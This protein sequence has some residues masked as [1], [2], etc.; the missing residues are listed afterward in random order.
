MVLAFAGHVQIVPVEGRGLVAIGESEYE[1]FGGSRFAQLAELIDGRREEQEILAAGDREALAGAIAELRRAGLLIDVPLPAGISG[2]TWWT[3]QGINPAVAEAR[4]RQTEVGVRAMPGVDRERT[5]G[6]MRDAGLR[7]ARAGDLGVVLVSDYLQDGLAEINAAALDDGRAW[8]LARPSGAQIFAGPVF[9]PHRGPCWECLAQRLREHRSLVRRMLV[10]AHAAD[11][12]GV[13]PIAPLETVGPSLIATE[14]VRWLAGAGPGLDSH[15]LSFDPRRW[16]G[17]RHRVV[18]RPQCPA[19]GERDA[20]LQRGAAPIRLRRRSGP[21]HSPEPLR[22]VA[23]EVMLE[24]FGHHISEVTGAVPGL[25]RHPGP[26][27]MHVY[28]TRAPAVRMHGDPDGWEHLLGAQ[29]SGKGTTDA[30]ARASALCEALERYSGQFAGDEPR[31]GGTFEELRSDAI[32]P[33]ACMGFSSA[34][35]AERTRSNREARS[36]RTYVP[37]PFDPTAPIDWTPAWSL[38]G[39][40]ERLLPT[41]LCYY[42][43]DVP[44]QDA[45]LADSNGNAAGNT[46]EEAVLHGLLELIERDHVALWWYNALAAPRV[47]LDS[48]DDTW[49][50]QVCRH[51]HEQGRDLWALDLTA[52]LG[53]PVSAALATSPDGTRVAMGYGAGLD[54]EGAV[55]RAITELVQLGLGGG[56][57]GVGSLPAGRLVELERHPF[58]RDSDAG[59]VACTP[60]DAFAGDIDD[61]L[62]RCRLA[63]EAQGIEILVLD[64]TRPDIGLPVVKVIAPGM[65]HFW[66]RFAPGRLYA[67]PVALG[68]LARPHAEHELNA[69]LPT[70]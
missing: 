60:S 69:S 66:P 4:I 38:S 20:S 15:V 45:C 3:S 24:R 35:Y 17:G 39:E 43:A 33:N 13:S 47:E 1:V 58:L 30:Q 11:V 12:K 7:V 53:I 2:A 41:A 56:S 34:Q 68:H 14:L 67:V 65:R 27:F 37:E 51:L 55:V 8:M 16:Q 18:W 63:I 70:L 59:T 32:H 6:A 44:G 54:L 52:D 49:V 23:P 36:V 40:R 28:G 64:Q 62:D 10:S 57:G 25:S 29:A 61:A 48:I 9:L 46:M 5:V 22:R 42:G 26:P 21:R 31:R 19:C 50:L